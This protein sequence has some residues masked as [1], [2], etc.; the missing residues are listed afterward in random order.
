MQLKA[1]GE[2][3][4][5]P[6]EDRGSAGGGD[7]ARDL[8]GPAGCVYGGVNVSEREVRASACRVRRRGVIADCKDQRPQEGEGD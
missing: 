2:S 7:A 1:R 4:L 5:Q 3:R 8:H 6:G